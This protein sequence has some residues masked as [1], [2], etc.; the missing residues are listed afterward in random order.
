MP[1]EKK[2]IRLLILEDSQNEAER[3]VSL[4]RNSGRSTRVHRLTSADELQE[5]LQQT[6][7]LLIA[8]PSSENLSP[9]D[10]LA[11]IRRLSKDIPVMQLVEGPDFDA[12]TEAMTLGASTALPQG[13]DEL[14]VLQA[15]RELAS[16]EDRRS[17]RAAE[18]ALRESEKRCQLLLDSSIDSIAY[19][20]D[21]MH[22][23][24]NRSY[25]ALFEY[26]DADELA[27][28]PM[29]DLVSGNDQAA[30]KDFMKNYRDE[31]EASDLAFQGMTANGNTFAARMSFSPATYDS[32][33]C[34]QVV[35]RRETSNQ[36]SPASNQDLVTG[37]FNRHHF[38]ELMDK[39]LDRSVHAGKAASLAFMRVDRQSTLLASI[40]I[41][42]MD[43]LLADLAKMLREHFPEQVQLARFSDDAFTA[44]IPD[45]SPDQTEAALKALLKTAETHLFDAD[46]RT[47]QITLSIGVAALDEQTTRSQDVIDRAHRCADDLKDG[48]ALKLFNPADELEAAA[49]RGDMLAMIQHAMEN[50]QFRLLFQPVV[51]LHGDSNE[52]YE[53]L[54][55]ML[56]PQGAEVPPNEFLAAA[57][58]EGLSA[59]IDR[60]VVLSSIKML[61]EHR[62]KGHKTNL[63]IQLSSASLQDQTLLPWLNL[64]LKAARLPADALIFQFSEQD[65]IQYLKQAKALTQ[66]LAELHC[67]VSL[68]QFGCA[69]NPF[70]TLKHLSVDF[71]KVDGSYTQ[72]LAN[73]ESLEAL[74]VLLNSLHAQTKLTI[75]PL[76]ETAAT[77]AALW[78]TG[79]NYI[80]GYFL[81]G[82]SPT[83]NYEFSS[84]DE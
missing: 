67:K 48:N 12:I 80:Q 42:G 45:Q 1:I 6:W 65:A 40:G 27:G 75:V 28:I 34:I 78:Q 4:F 73:P 38:I 74:K 17:K 55:R 64:A 15:N 82:P 59:K 29:I 43:L 7:D 51:S 20:H 3:L 14:L 26:E 79:V 72:D 18:L 61:T 33:P 52:Q 56:N 68:S 69:A 60:W 36:T 24:A 10:A 9:N 47:V 46:G 41:A 35:I 63:F 2:T 39:A 30:F 44:L 57:N 16:L 81:Q 37:L 71:V 50:N 58:E 8:A 49:S 5:I 13:E 22:I 70:N 32:E 11:A 53:V 31:N 23:Y 62:S 54:V 77:M 66:G 84:G 19:V 25:L 21:G 76:V 83:M